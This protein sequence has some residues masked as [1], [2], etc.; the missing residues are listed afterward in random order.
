M[1][2]IA[3]LFA[4]GLLC[5]SNATTPEIQL[6]DCWVQTFKSNNVDLVSEIQDFENDLIKNGYIKDGSWNSYKRLIDSLSN[7]NKPMI[8]RTIGMREFSQTSF[9]IDKQCFD[10]TLISRIPKLS[11]L[12][13]EFQKGINNKDLGYEFIYSKI[14]STIDSNDFNID[15]YKTWIN[16]I[17][18]SNSMYSN[19]IKDFLPKDDPNEK[20]SITIKIDS[21]NQYYI[22]NKLVD[23]K[24]IKAKLIELGNSSDK[25][26]IG[27]D[28][29]MSVSVAKMIE[30]MELCNDNNLKIKIIT[31]DK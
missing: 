21:L 9:I 29:H 5:C 13:N 31:G 30:I 17:L 14:S 22:D 7:E 27:F 23:L 18:I 8:R 3:L 11:A 12:L 28:M 4:L 2:S 6:Y 25:L 15:L 20:T 24:K 19:W 16:W 10:S 1:K 26:K